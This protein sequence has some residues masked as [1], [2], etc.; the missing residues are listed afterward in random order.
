MAQNTTKQNPKML[1]ARAFGSS[2]TM[3]EDAKEFATNYSKTELQDA[4]T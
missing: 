2:I 1:G 4:G 3:V